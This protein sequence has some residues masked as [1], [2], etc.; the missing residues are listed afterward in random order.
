M[1]GGAVLLNV[2]ATGRTVTQQQ[3]KVNTKHERE[4]YGFGR[5]RVGPFGLFAPLL[6]CKHIHT[7]VPR[8]ETCAVLQIITSEH[9]TK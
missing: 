6:I 9:T 5:L 4:V 2:P 8:L 3:C 7:R 1:V